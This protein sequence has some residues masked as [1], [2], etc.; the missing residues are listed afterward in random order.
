LL[1]HP[2]WTPLLSRPVAPLAVATRERLLRMLTDAG[3]SPEL[4]LRT[5]SAAI[6]SAV[7]LALVEL[8]FREP[9]GESSF[10]K[11][12][13]PLRT[14]FESDV[15]QRESVVKRAASSSVARLDLSDTFGFAMQ[16]LVDGANTRS[17]PRKRSPEP[18]RD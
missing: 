3:M 7:G 14:W 16:S 17:T 10:G 4:A 6:L 2:R 11:R 15:P 12:F 9:D 5:V 18:G 1:E 13:D 8:T